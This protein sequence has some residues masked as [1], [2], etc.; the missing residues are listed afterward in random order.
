MSIVVGAQEGFRLNMK[1]TMLVKGRW[2][3]THCTKAG[4]PWT[5]RLP[6]RREALFPCLGPGRV[7][8]SLEK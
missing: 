2:P 8:S 3:L 6:V 5:Q 4:F 7:S 1:L